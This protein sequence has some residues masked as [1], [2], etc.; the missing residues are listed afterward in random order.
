[1]I[2]TD[3]PL[4][5]ECWQWEESKEGRK[6]EM[7]ERRKRGGREGK[8]KERRK[9]GKKGEREGRRKEGGQEPGGCGD[10]RAVM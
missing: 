8:G 4:W 3:T 2:V 10:K 1:M 9:G 5:G 6:G 7:K